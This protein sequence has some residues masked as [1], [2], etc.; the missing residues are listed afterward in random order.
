MASSRNTAS[1]VRLSDDGELIEEAAAE[2]EVVYCTNCG[3]K[4][5]LDSNFCRTC[6]ESLQEQSGRAPRKSK[7]AQQAVDRAM[8][9]HADPALIA[10]VG[11]IRLAV[12]GAM[13]ILMAKV[14]PAP[15]DAIVPVVIV[16][17]GLVG[18]K[19]FK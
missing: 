17:F 14:L 8:Q 1:A 18:D 3:A 16:F 7:L 5:Q 2:N 4:N 6:G 11:V 15:A 13:A 9:P 12:V 10:F 19:I